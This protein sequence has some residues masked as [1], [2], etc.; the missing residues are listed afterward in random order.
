MVIRG[1]G[2][3]MVMGVRTGVR[4]WGSRVPIWYD[5]HRGLVWVI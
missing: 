2:M 5:M 1:K 4:T 3:G